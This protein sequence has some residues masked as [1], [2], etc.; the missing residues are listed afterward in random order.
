MTAAPLSAAERAV[1]DGA[2]LIAAERQRQIDV[3]GWTPEH[4]AQH[5]PWQLFRAGMAYR[6]RDVRG[7]PW[8]RDG[9]KPRS[10]FRNLVRAGA[11]FQASTEAYG[12]SWRR[13]QALDERDRCAAL[14]DELIADVL[15]AVRSA[16][17]GGQS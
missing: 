9:F 4:D 7:W 2:A 10:E 15:A 13:R 14:L 6:S 16:G 11:L 8:E 17:N 1:V 12:T 3:E 5:D